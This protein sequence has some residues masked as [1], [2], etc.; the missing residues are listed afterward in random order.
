MCLVLSGD[1]PVD[2]SWLFNDYPVNSYSG[3]SIS[4]VSKKNSI[5]TIE[6]VGGRHAG[7][8]TCIARNEANT[9]SH[10]AE[11]IVNG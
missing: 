5:L 1:L 6:S 4:K 2:I 10:S 11:L 8:Y 3:I 7:N 9:V